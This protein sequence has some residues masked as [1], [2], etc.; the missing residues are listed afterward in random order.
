MSKKILG[1]GNAIVDVFVKVDDDFLLKSNLTKGSMKLLEKKEFENLKSEIKIEKI[2]AGGSV[3]NTMAGIAYLG[4][5]PSFIGK[6]NSDEFGKIY[7]KSLEKIKVDFHYIEKNENL[8][9]GA[10]II[11]ITPDSER[12]MCTY[13]GISSQ[14]TKDDI[15][16]DHIKDHEIIFLEG[17][18]WDKGMSEEMFKHVINIAKKNDIKIAMSL[19][20]IFC[21]TRH[22]EDFLKLLKNDLNILI[23]N[24]NE[25]NELV[26]K[27]SLL[28]SIE[29]LKK[30]NKLIV[31]T[32][33][34]NGSLAILNNKIINCKSINVKKV[35]DVTG[36]GDLFAS[37][38][39]K[40]Y[41]DHSD[42]KKC[43][44]RG[45][46]I[47]AKIIQKVGARI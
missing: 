35:L 43:L 11:F 44:E 38:F 5:N 41:L 17:Y 2:E 32:R 3:A 34:Q 27:K 25:I 9:T 4:G 1:I 40:E 12:T 26:E 33:S 47:A 24:E 46:E 7:K 36:A 13:L 22:R 37:G 39:L 28:D 15:I 8:S 45:S 42:I 29:V 6:I 21:V 31:I 19:S 14:L 10:S 18:L 20:D 30:I 23:G 16:E